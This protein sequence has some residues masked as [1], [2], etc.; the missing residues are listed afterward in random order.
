MKIKD[1]ASGSKVTIDLLASKV[2]RGVT[3]NGAPYLSITFQDNSGEIEAKLWDV[4]SEVEKL[5][6]AGKVYR[7]NVDVNMYRQSLQL[8]IHSLTL[9]SETEYSLDDFVVSPQFNKEFLKE[10]IA[11]YRTMI[12]DPVLHKLVT[13]CFDYYGDAFFEYP[14]ATRNHH[15][16]VGGLATHVYGMCQLALVITDIY[17][18]VY[19]RD[20]LLAGILVHDM[21]KIDEYTAPILSEYSSLGRLVGHISIM[22]ANLVKIAS[23]LGLENT[24]QAMLLRHMILSHHGQ[25][26]YGSPVL[27]LV[28]EAELLNFIDNLDARTNMFSKIYKTINE[29]EFGTRTFAL[30]NRSFYKANY[31]DDVEEH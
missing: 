10:K 21:G 16:F 20:L 7:I 31:N 18:D 13:A 8:R 25:Y 28:K 11:M 24:E 1:L 14:A 6:E 2:T 17:P 23:E 15:D 29:G 9:L 4:K 22:Q 26:E 3:Q 27:P 30:E 19:D 5:V 12:Q